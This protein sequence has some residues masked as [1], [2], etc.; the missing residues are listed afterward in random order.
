MAAILADPLALLSEHLIKLV[1]H[2]ARSVVAVHGGRRATSTGIQWRPGIIVT[3][4]E[5][6][7][8]DEEITVTLPDGRKAEVTLVGRDPST[9]VAALRFA[10]NGMPVAEID[11]APTLRTGAIVLAVGRNAEGPIASHGIVGFAGGAWQ[12]QRGGTI[13][14]LLRLD[15]ALSPASDGGALVDATGRV[16]GMT[17]L[18]PRGRAL[19]IPAATVDRVLDQLLAKGHISRGYLGASLQRVRLGTEGA[20]RGLLVVGLDPEGPAARAGIVVGDILTA[21]NGTPLAH[22]RELLRFLGSNSVDTKVLLD[23]LR[24]GAP[25]AI[26][27]TIGERP[28]A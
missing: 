16:H 23:V 5:A 18:G 25:Q 10:P 26:A 12:S 1:D 3:A 4:E 7:E 28:L 20:K 22:V 8:Q 19:A 14:R 17:V 11:D 21:W 6:L 9:D 13:D 24:A 27:V 2:A 15:L